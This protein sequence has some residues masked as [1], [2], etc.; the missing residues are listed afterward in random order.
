MPEIDE[1]LKE[2]S[3]VGESENQ[4]IVESNMFACNGNS[5]YVYH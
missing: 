2:T 5:Y 1:A 4:G 3:G